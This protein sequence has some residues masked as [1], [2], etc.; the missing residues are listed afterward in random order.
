MRGVVNREQH[1]LLLLFGIIVRQG[2]S[3]F[4]QSPPRRLI[5]FDPHLH[6]CSLLPP[7]TAYFYT[8]RF[9]HFSAH[10]IIMSSTSSSSNS[11]NARAYTTLAESLVRDVIDATDPSPEQA[12]DILSA[13]QKE[14]K[15]QSI[16]A[17]RRGNNDN[18]TTTTSVIE[19]LK[20]SKIG[21]ILT[22]TIKACKRHGRN[23]T[24][25]A[26]WDTAIA[27]AEEILS[28]MKMT[29]DDEATAA[30]KTAATA[31]K[32]S[33]TETDVAGGVP[34]SVTDFR[35][36]LITQKKELY[37]DPPSYPP[38][39]ITIASNV[40]PLPTRN[41]KTGELSFELL[42]RDV[43]FTPNRTP[44]EVLRAGSFG[45]TYFRPITSAVTNVQYT[46]S[47]VLAD[48]V[49]PSWITG[50][51]K[52]TVLTSMT[53][54][55]AVNKFGVK[56]GGSLGMWESSGWISNVDP[57]GWFQWYCRFYRGRRTSDDA[58]QISRWAGVAGIK[59]RFRSQL[60]NKIIAANT[61]CDD[62]KISPVIRQTLLHWGLE[63]T[64]DV[65][66]KHKK[67]K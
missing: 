14:W 42:P 46:S 45:G 58:R 41:P 33:S 57:Y 52:K 21:N 61:T 44:E 49:E 67:R 29:A 28:S 50:L 24:E 13:V 37:K 34:S 19:L 11:S 9:H 8:R 3:S 5:S 66:S 4:Q 39:N 25:K 54:R 2:G 10:T 55:N 15:K 20:V 27:I 22:K 17:N 32:S 18:M 35:A 62:R 1:Q 31:K 6:H 60:C 43:V 38:I 30:A 12:N 56:C 26:T 48:T 36:R 7:T 63:I 59:G 40:A 23:S 53:Y 47:T 65:L 16:T 64:E 51:D